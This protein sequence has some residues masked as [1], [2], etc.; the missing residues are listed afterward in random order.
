MK[1]RN[2]ISHD[3]TPEA[4]EEARTKLFPETLTSV[5]KLSSFNNVSEEEVSKYIKKSSLAT[6]KLDPAPTSIIKECCAELL[7]N[8]TMIVHKS[9]QYGILSNRLKHADENHLLKINV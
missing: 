9:I 7:S 3:A 5:H 4:M 8:M 2:S 6:C 1:T